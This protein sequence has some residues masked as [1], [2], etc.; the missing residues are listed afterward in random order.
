MYPGEDACI[1]EIAVYTALIEIEKS[2][3]RPRQEYLTA[4][5]R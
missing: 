2:E 1:E 5:S 4:C 3:S